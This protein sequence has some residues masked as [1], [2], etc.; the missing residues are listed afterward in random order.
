MAGNVPLQQIS[1]PIQTNSSTSEPKWLRFVLISIALIFLGIFL[2]LPLITIFIQAFDQGVKVYLA[3]I[4]EPDALAAIKLTLLVAVIAVPLNAIFGVAAAWAVSKFQF[5][6]KNLLITL[7]D[8][9]FAVSPV[10]AG[11]VFVLLFSTH[12]LF[13]E[14][15]FA[16]NI[17]IIFAVP[18]IVLATVFV[19][20]PFV[21]RELIP[22]MQAQGTSEEEASLTLGAGGWKTFWYVTLPN[23]KWGLLYG[24][25]LCN[26][27]AIGEF[28]AVSVVSGHIRGLTNTMPLHIE[29]LYGEYR[30]AAA[31]AVATLMSIL[32][33]ITL[34][35]KSLLEWKTKKQLMNN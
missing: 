35:I 12:G 34:I 22:L 6:G 23:I 7:I 27:R 15:L 17:K 18:G 28:G 32:A 25:I 21:A 4:T 13:G 29:I 2:L 26:A 30:F 5:K 8:L 20:L 16:H 1:A 33:I 3:A 10:I 24:V 19:T 14:W 11:L 31:F 9:P